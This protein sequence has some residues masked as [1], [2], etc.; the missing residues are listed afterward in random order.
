MVS[1]ENKKKQQK[2]NTKTNI[3]GLGFRILVVSYLL[4]LRRGCIWSLTLGG[5]SSFPL[6][7]F[8]KGGCW[9]FHRSRKILVC[10][11]SFRHW[12]WL[13]WGRRIRT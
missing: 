8:L 12:G 5:L 2:E 3:L 7:G 13:L 9:D 4:G 11:W 6:T 1:I 10:R